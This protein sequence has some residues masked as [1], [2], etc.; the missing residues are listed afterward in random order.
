MK[1]IKKLNEKEIL[2]QEELLPILKN[3]I[4][5]TKLSDNDLFTFELYSFSKGQSITN[6]K[7]VNS[8]FYY[9]TK[10]SI[11][12]A[13]DLLNKGD[14][15]YKEQGSDIGFD[16]KEDT[17]LF[18]LTLKKDLKMEHFESNKVINLEEYTKAVPSCVSSNTLVQNKSISLTLLSLD[19]AEGLSTH[20]ASGDAMVIALDG[21]VNIHID[22]VP[23]DVRKNE[24]L[25]LPYGIPH[26]LKAIKPFKMLL[27]VIY[28]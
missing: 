14:A 10:G 3:Q 15:I 4:V 18:A 6:S 12:I 2:N 7:A 11:N 28:I 19:S 1:F 9:I 16:A 25:I 8:S 23:F 27:I 20:A 21:E 17:L 26:S 5:S 22:D 24:L 13:L